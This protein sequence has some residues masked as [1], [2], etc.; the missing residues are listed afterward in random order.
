M[1]ELSQFTQPGKDYM[2][3]LWSQA[4]HV[5]G[6][7][8]FLC[9]CIAP[10]PS[11]AGTAEP[12]QGFG[13]WCVWWLF[14]CLWRNWVKCIHTVMFGE[15]RRGIQLQTWTICFWGGGLGGGRLVKAPFPP[16]KWGLDIFVKLSNELWD[17][18][19]RLITRSKP[20]VNP[21]SGQKDFVL[22]WHKIVLWVTCRIRDT[23]FHVNVAHKGKNL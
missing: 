14:N 23:S 13:R 7:P 2:P 19:Q 4:I 1:S 8:K 11:R 3:Q 10:L 9:S 16:G 12:G 6:F 15:V 18:T 20:E 17:G 21:D 5:N 22:C